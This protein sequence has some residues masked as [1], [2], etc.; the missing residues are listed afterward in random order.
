MQ[1][2]IQAMLYC[3]ATVHHR[4]CEHV[5]TIDKAVTGVTESTKGQKLLKKLKETSKMLEEIIKTR[6]QKT[7]YF[8][9][10]IEVALVE[11]ANLRE[12]INKKLDELENKIREEV[13]STRKNYVLRLTEELSELVSLKSTFDNWKN[14][15]EACLLQGSEIQCLVKMEEIIRK[16]PNLE[17]RFVESYT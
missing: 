8:E 13:N 12:K 16:M 11:I 10:E 3:C 9:K 1:G 4:K 17:K 15:F 7:T 2:S 5:I 14:L 6:E